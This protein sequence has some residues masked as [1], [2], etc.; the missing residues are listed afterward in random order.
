[1]LYLTG[2]K[3]SMDILIALDKNQQIKWQTRYGNSFVSYPESRSIPT[4]EKDRIYV[5]SGTGEVACINAL[6][7]KILWKI[8]AKEKYGCVPA[9]WGVAE[10]LLLYKDMVYYTTGGDKTT[11]IA[12]N[13]FTGDKVW[14]SDTVG[15]KRS[16]ASPILIQRGGKNLVVTVTERHILAFEAENGK[17][18]WKFD[19]SVY[20]EPYGKRTINATT[21][22]YLDGN[23]YV[24]SGYNHKSVMLNLAE[25]ASKV[26]L[27]WIDSVL[28]NHHGG[29]VLVNGYIYGSNWTDNGNG[30]WCCIDWKTGKKKYEEK[31][32]TKGSII[33]ADGMLYCYEEK[34]GN[35]AL[36]K[37]NPEKFE[38]VSS[39][40][41]SNGTGVHWAHPVIKDGIL[42]VRH[43]ECLMAY[44]I[45]D[46]AASGM[47]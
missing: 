24:T 41:I 2:N 46:T 21:P 16:Y 18:I 35:L 26:T 6:D 36:V 28:D 20:S 31:W 12:L 39:Y 11:M 25:D 47:K 27:A 13:K 5:T 40:K 10:S 3:D 37:A 45:K 22:L 4:I 19:Y 14:V 8:D 33:S 15:D 9:K 43:G 29:V 1:M 30:K 44:N 32:F 7:G 38:I 42:Y 17:I 34:T 23:I